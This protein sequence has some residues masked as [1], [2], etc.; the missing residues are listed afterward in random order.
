VHFHIPAPIIGIMV[1]YCES[2]CILLNY[3]VNAGGGEHFFGSFIVDLSS[4]ATM[5]SAGS[6]TTVQNLYHHHHQ[7]KESI[8]SQ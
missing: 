8:D 6:G 2:Q 5:S 3:K 1:S 4:F 7:L